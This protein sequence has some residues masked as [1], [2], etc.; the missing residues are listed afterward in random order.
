MRIKKIWPFKKITSNFVGRRAH[1]YK[2]FIEKLGS[3][4]FELTATHE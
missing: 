1:V 4:H 2:I 3:E